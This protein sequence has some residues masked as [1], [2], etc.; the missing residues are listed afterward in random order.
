MTRRRAP[1]PM[2]YDDRLGDRVSAYRVRED[3]DMPGIYTIDP[4]PFHPQRLPVTPGPD[5]THLYRLRPPPY[6]TPAYIIPGPMTEDYVP[7]LRRDLPSTPPLTA[8]VP[9]LVAGTTAGVAHGGL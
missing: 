5:G 7:S 6:A 4:D 3:G 9:I 8:R 2:T 1:K